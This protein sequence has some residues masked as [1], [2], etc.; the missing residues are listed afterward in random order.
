MQIQSKTETK[1]DARTQLVVPEDVL[2]RDLSGESV[3]LNLRTEAYFGLDEVGTDMWRALTRGCSV[4]AA[5]K[6]LTSLYDITPDTLE[7]DLFDLAGKLIDHALLEVHP[8]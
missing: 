1:V 5:L 2:V 8:E 7:R 4:G 6:E 3:L